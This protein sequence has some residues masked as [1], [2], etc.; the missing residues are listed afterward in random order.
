MRNETLALLASFAAMSL[1]VASYFVKK[2]SYYL[3]LQILGILLLVVSYFFSLQFFA[4]IG[5]TIGLLRTLTFFLYEKK[6]KAS[7]IY[8][9]F[10]F[11]AVTISAYFI[12]NYVILKKSQPLDVLCLL[13]LVMYAFIFRIRNLKIVRF[14]ML[15]PLFLSALFN[16]LT[17]AA[18]FATLSYS[19]E[20]CANVVSI[21]KYHIFRAKETN[22]KQ[23]ESKLS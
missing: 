17:H 19:F 8:W 18:I 20:F 22:K 15:I 4:M 3:L 11:S 12:L 10:F 21:I 14:T 16:F 23:N 1:V 2:K 13:S 5:L 9:S 7:P 6:E